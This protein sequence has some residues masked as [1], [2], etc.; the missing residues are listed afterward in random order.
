MLLMRGALGALP[1]SVQSQALDP[2]RFVNTTIVDPTA[3]VGNASP[4]TPMGDPHDTYGAVVGYCN[5]T[6]TPGVQATPEQ[7]ANF[8]A[9]MRFYA[10]GNKGDWNQSTPHSYS[11]ILPPPN[12]YYFTA[13]QFKL[14]TFV[15]QQASANQNAVW[16]A[17]MIQGLTATCPPG[18]DMAN[19]SIASPGTFEVA[20]VPFHIGEIKNA[21]FDRT[22][23]PTPEQRF[24]AERYIIGG[25]RQSYHQKF[26]SWALKNVAKTAGNGPSIREAWDAIGL[27]T[28]WPNFAFN[29]IQATADEFNNH[30]GLFKWFARGGYP[31]MLDVLTGQANA[32]DEAI[33]FSI[34]TSTLCATP[35]GVA[36]ARGW[37]TKEGGACGG[38]LAPCS[39]SVMDGVP[40]FWLRFA[41][42][43]NPN[44]EYHIS[45]IWD[46][47]GK[48]ERFADAMSSVLSRLADVLCAVQPQAQAQEQKL[49]MEKCVDEKTHKL[50]IKGKP[51]CKC[52]SPPNST[53]VAVGM[54]NYY[55]SQW[56]KSWHEQGAVP[57]PL[58]SP[59]PNPLPTK[60]YW[61]WIIGGLA[62]AS[63]AMYASR[64]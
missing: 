52:V 16:Q 63:G 22:Y 27:R 53:A 13:D 20:R 33:T 1:F 24:W 56:C 15:N 38:T 64:K 51:G 19:E 9:C 44:G 2:S 4:S 40:S 36:C 23:R 5:R 6:I 59:I 45:L 17:A 29:P 8:N 47:P 58:P 30:G 10:L 42:D 60:N 7:R 28:S 18:Y 54:T 32:S 46:K 21:R 3:L 41:I 35:N 34:C 48:L 57:E 37:M 31:L 61:P 49:L 55:T 39:K 62:I 11:M 14:I 25:S 50:C 26:A 12:R 43:P